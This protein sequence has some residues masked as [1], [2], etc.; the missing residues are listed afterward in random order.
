MIKY[1]LICKNCEISFDSWFSSSSEYEKLKKKRFLK[2]HYCNSKNI[3]KTLM[4]P[5]MIT[6]KSLG[7]FN[8]DEKKLKNIK[9]TLQEYQKF[10]KNNF[11][12][13]ED[14]FT[15]EARTIHYNKKKQEKGI[16]GTASKQDL[17]EL[18]EEGIDAQMI[19]WVEDKDN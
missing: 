4:A 19:P 15:Y 11:K 1:K 8:K 18:K 6:N 17:K 13:V 9:K 7:K 14:N 3:E 2:C 12:Y 16:Y 5:N 10:I